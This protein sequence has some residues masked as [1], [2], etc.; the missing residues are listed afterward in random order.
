MNAPH[1]APAASPLTRKRPALL[2]AL[3]AI[4]LVWLLLAVHSLSVGG[5]TW[6]ELFDFEGVNGAFWHGIN[7]LKGTRPELSSITFDLEWYGNAT[8]W[9]TYLLWRL[10]MSEPWERIT[11]L[12]R[13]QIVLGSSYVALNHLNAMVFALLGIGL[14][15]VLGTRLGGRRVGLLA[16]GLLLLLPAWLG[17][18]WINSKDIPMAASYL[19]Y[20]LGSTLLLRGDRGGGPLRVVGIGLMTGSR[21]SSLAFIAIG[22]AVL[23]VWLGR[24]APRRWL[25]SLGGGLLMGFLLTPQAWGIPSATRSRRSTSSANGRP[26]AP[27]CR[28]STIWPPTSSICSPPPS[29]WGCC[30]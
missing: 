10:L 5:V 24:Q 8:R 9:P 19:L 14:T 18:G 15:G 30:C 2:I 27:P 13:A 17:H 11:S 12:S 21:V 1:P 28:P 25:G 4:G 20:T 29:C 23:S 22:E 3:P 6:D 7:W 16:A 26:S